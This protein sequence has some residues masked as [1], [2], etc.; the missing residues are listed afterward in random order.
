VAGFNPQDPAS[1]PQES[2]VKVENVMPNDD[3]ARSHG[4]PEAGDE[5][6]FVLAGEDNFARHIAVIDQHSDADHSAGYRVQRALIAV[7]VES[8][9]LN[10]HCN[11]PRV[12]AFNERSLLPNVCSSIHLWFF[13]IPD[14]DVFTHRVREAL[15]S[16][17]QLR[18]MCHKGIR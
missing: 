16:V 18:F 1:L 13:S 15:L 8:D 5:L 6:T 9:G 4:A 10:V 12:N 2:K 14:Q 17:A 7:W 3:I 11:Y